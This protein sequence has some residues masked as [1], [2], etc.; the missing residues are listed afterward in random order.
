MIEVVD[1][2]IGVHEQEG[3]SIFDPFVRLH[4]KHEYSG[5]G[6]G[7]AICKTLCERMEWKLS[8]SPNPKGGT[9]FF[10]E[11]KGIM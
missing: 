4:S 2:G 1:N 10:L 5:S 8:H 6:I 9:V 11:M 3:K 7:L